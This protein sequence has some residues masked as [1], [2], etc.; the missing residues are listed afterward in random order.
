[1]RRAVGPQP[2][3]LPISPYDKDDYWQSSYISLYLPISP[4]ISLYLPIS[5]NQDADYWQRPHHWLAGFR[6]ATHSLLVAFDRRKLHDV[7]ARSE[8]LQDAASAAEVADLWGKLRAARR[9][10]VLSE[11]LVGA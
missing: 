10:A 1:V 6:A 11:Y 8:A 4:Y 3:E 5:P 7:I 2:G 9:Q